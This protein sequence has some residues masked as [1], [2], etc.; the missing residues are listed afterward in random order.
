MI[1]LSLLSVPADVN[2]KMT[3][4]LF[5]GVNVTQFTEVDE[6]IITW[7][8]VNRLKDGSHNISKVVKAHLLQWHRFIQICCISSIVQSYVFICWLL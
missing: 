3:K 7:V 5:D 6:E 1:A 8:P 2:L 4:V